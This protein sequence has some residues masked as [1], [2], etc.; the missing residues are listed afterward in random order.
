MQ[1]SMISCLFNI[2]HT[3]HIQHDDSIEITVYK[4]H[5]I[6]YDTLF[7]QLIIALLSL[8]M[9]PLKR[10]IIIFINLGFKFII[11]NFFI[12][13]FKKLIIAFLTFKNTH[14]LINLSLFL[15]YKKQGQKCKSI[16]KKKKPHYCTFI[17][18]HNAIKKNYYYFHHLNKNFVS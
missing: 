9:M 7:T 13:G 6:L 10:T 1:F 2:I 14:N 17:T 15:K 4:L 11:I 8:V 18:C 3:D 16:K 5:Y 12:G